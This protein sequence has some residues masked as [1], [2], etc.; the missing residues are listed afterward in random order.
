VCLGECLAPASS[1][2]ATAPAGTLT[3]KISRHD[4]RLS[5]P[6]RTGPEV[7]AATPPIDHSATARARLTGSG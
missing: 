4:T 5:S 3:K 7:E 2:S 1:S 6:P